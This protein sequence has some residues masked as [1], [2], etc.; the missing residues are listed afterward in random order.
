MWL[1]DANVD[2]HLAALLGEFGIVAE[3]AITRGWETLVNGDLLTAAVNARFAC[4][5]TRDRRFAESAASAL[6]AHP[7]FAIVIVSLPQ[8]PSHQYLENFRIAWS[9][10][11]IR[12]LPGKMLSWPE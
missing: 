2:V 12:P 8:C 3:S 1:L 6:K 7:D 9:T 11:C 5:L 4:L 10:N